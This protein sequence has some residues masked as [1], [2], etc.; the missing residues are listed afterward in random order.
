MPV[1]S[2]YLLSSGPNSHSMTSSVV[3]A[4]VLWIF[5]SIVA[6]SIIHALQVIPFAMAGKQILSRHYKIMELCNI[7]LIEPDLRHAQSITT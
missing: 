1:I 7:I 3:G 4:S 2:C 5:I 6:A